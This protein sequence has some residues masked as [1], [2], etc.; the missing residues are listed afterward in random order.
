MFKVPVGEYFPYPYTSAL[1]LE[2]PCHS[3]NDTIFIT[4][5]QLRIGVGGRVRLAWLRGVNKQYAIYFHSLSRSRSLLT[6]F[7]RPSSFGIGAEKSGGKTEAAAA[8]GIAL[9]SG[10]SSR[11][12][13]GL[14][15]AAHVGAGILFT[16]A[17]VH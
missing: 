4:N 5:L 16:Y 12:E 11:R 3:L 1:A 6:S 2:T 17:Y 15:L 9:L 8:A 13:S 14:Q 10:R 7:V